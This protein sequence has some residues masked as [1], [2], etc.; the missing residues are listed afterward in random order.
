MRDTSTATALLELA[1]FSQAKIHLVKI[2]SGDEEGNK[3]A[4]KEVEG[5]TGRVDVLWANAGKL[6]SSFRQEGRGM[7]QDVFF[8]CLSH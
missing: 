4:A 3:A 2:V 5:L 7:F 6:S 8:P 1:K